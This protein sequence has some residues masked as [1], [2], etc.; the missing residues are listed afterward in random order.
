MTGSSGVGSEPGKIEEEMGRTALHLRRAITPPVL[1]L[2]ELITPAAWNDNVA[3]VIKK[4][5]EYII[6]S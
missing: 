3:P 5:F 4:S 2:R 1:P 6:D